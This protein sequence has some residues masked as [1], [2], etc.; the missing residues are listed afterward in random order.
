MTRREK[1]ERELAR[2]RE[3]LARQRRQF[4]AAKPRS[5]FAYAAHITKTKGRI[6]RLERE[7]GP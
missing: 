6:A 4:A 1:L 2:Q 7:L 3:I 5:R